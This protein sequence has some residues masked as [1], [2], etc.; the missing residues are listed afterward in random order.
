MPELERAWERALGVIQRAATF[1]R[2]REKGGTIYG[3]WPAK[4]GEKPSIDHR[5]AW[6][7][8]VVYDPL[9][10]RELDS[11]E[12]QL[13]R[14][15]PDVLRRFYTGCANGVDLLGGDVAV[16]GLRR[17]VLLDPYELELETIE[18]PADATASHAFFGSWG[19]ENNLLYLDADD[20]RVHLSGRSSV[21]PLRTWAGLGEF[22]VATLEEYASCWDAD[23]RRLGTLPVPE[24]PAEPIAA[25]RR[26][27]RV[28]ED[29]RDRVEQLREALSEAPES[30]DVGDGVVRLAS[31]DELGGLQLGFGIG[32]DGDDLSGAKPGDWRA[33]W[34]VIGIDEDLGD[35]F[36]VDLAGPDMPVFTA[37]HGA[38]SWDPQPVAPSLRTLLVSGL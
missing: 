2:Q 9:D 33:S 29:L 15:L 26:E 22:L 20:D 35:P 11:L 4:P 24:E 10:E 31:P 14:A 32:P 5:V 1:G 19:G 8:H 16:Y 21:S 6:L 25:P 28:P 37:M 36:F 18:A 30:L 13:G 27:L 34:I 17:G 7:R 23:G 12:R 3:W 38:G